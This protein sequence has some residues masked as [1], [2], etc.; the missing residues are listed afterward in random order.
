MSS[1]STHSSRHAR[2]SSQT[3]ERKSPIT[4]IQPTLYT[5]QE[6]DISRKDIA[7]E[8]LKVLYR[9]DNAGYDAC[10]VGGAIRDLLLGIKPKDF[11]IVTNARPEQVRALFRNCRLI[12]RRFRLAHIYYGPH[13]IEVATYRKGHD[14]T[15]DAAEKGT[16][17]ENRNEMV[18]REGV[19]VRDNLYGTLEEDALRRDFTING[20][21]YRLSDFALLDY[22][23]AIDDMSDRVI[24]SIGDPMVRFQEDPVRML[25][26]VRFA[27]KLNFEIEPDIE[28]AIAQLQRE[29]HKVAP[30]RLFD[31]VLKLL[32]TGQGEESYQM[33]QRYGLFQVLFPICST[34]GARGEALSDALLLEALKNTDLR[35]R[36]EKG[37]NPAFMMAAILWA[38]F[39][40]EKL[41]YRKRGA[42]EFE[43]AEKAAA[44]VLGE[45]SRIVAIPRRFATVVWEIWSM[46]NRFERR[47]AKA[48]QR[49]SS[50]SRFRAAYDFLLLRSKIG[51]A[52]NELAE[53][54]TL[55]QE[56]NPITPSRPPSRS[57]KHASKKRYSNKK[58]KQAHIAS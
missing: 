10:L 40:R 16:R 1:S 21:Y 3:A 14:A 20:L 33:L 57:A 49:L 37:V 45:A 26:A 5:R 50:H 22:V 35:L 52:P 8:A 32:Q 30:A 48:P 6:H 2:P 9:L 34:K 11:D 53:W 7:P 18:E 28:H 47:R 15:G 24:R 46:Q 12:G 19:I 43:S 51:E 4:S 54:W 38:P 13:I 41:R 31:E 27:V 55:Y 39:C 25:R 44:Y 36:E 23:G 56:R 17:Y 58:S 29:I 42:K